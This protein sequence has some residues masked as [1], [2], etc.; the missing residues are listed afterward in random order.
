[1]M[2]AA[3]RDTH[4]PKLMPGDVAAS[5]RIDFTVL[6][7]H[8]LASYANGGGRYGICAAHADAVGPAVVDAH[9]SDRDVS[10]SAHR[11]NTV[12]A[13]SESVRAIAV[14]LDEIGVAVDVKSLNRHVV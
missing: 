13:L 9:V 6:D 12:S 10:A 4:V 14:L 3:I 1:M 7:H 5:V 8:L 11:Q 2:Q